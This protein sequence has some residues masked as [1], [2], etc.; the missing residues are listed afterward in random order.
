[1]GAERWLAGT[2]VAGTARPD[3]W[4]GEENL[5]ASEG[6]AG[7]TR[8]ALRHDG[9]PAGGTPE[10]GTERA[11]EHSLCRT[12]ESDAPRRCGSAGETDLGD[13]AGSARTRG[14]S[15]VVARLLPLRAAACVVA[16]AT[17]PATWARWTTQ[18]APLS[19]TDAGD[20]SWTDELA[21]DGQ[22][23]PALPAATRT[24]WGWL[25]RMGT[26]PDGSIL[27]GMAGGKAAGCF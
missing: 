26:S 14:A 16:R 13:S 4:S 7:H 10:A 19:T 22:R 15:G 9:G 27:T 21:L 20:G 1:M 17:R 25:T 18:A 6:G 2:S 11:A 12:G 5:S 8:D 24:S 3:L 23:P